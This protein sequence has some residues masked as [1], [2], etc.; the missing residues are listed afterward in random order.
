MSEPEEEPGSPG[1]T[2]GVKGGEKGNLEEGGEERRGTL[3]L[4][5]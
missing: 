5:F 4:Q 2:P 1:D 3:G